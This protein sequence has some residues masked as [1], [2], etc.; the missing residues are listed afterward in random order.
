MRYEKTGSKITISIEGDLN[1]RKVKE[2]EKILEKEGKN[3]VEIHFHCSKFI[4]TEGIKFIYML[5]KQG[6]DIKL[7]NPPKLFYKVVELLQLDF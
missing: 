7:K 4:D 1:L 5:K 3:S 2:I 6:V